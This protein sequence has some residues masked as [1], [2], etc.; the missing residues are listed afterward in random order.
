ML[1]S[2]VI[3][4]LV[5]IRELKLRIDQSIWKVV[6]LRS[7]Y[8]KRQGTESRTAY[9]WRLR[10]VWEGK[11]KSIAIYGRVATIYGTCNCI[12]NHKLDYFQFSYIF[13]EVLFLAEKRW[14]I[15][16]LSNRI[17]PWQEAL[18]SCFFLVSFSTSTILPSASVT[19]Y[20]DRFRLAITYRSR[21]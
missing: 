5:V 21:S 12:C 1:C 16:E 18:G 14:E 7:T 4:K 15:I 10:R 8:A 3:F 2:C 11:R 19:V 13:T 6:Q 9:S 17:P 20:P